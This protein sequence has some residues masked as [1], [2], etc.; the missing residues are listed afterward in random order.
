MI[1]KY[2]LNIGYT[3]IFILLIIKMLKYSEITNKI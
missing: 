2:E 3:P 1:L